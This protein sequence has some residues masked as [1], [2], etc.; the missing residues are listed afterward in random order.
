MTVSAFKDGERKEKIAEFYD[1]EYPT[2]FLRG[3]LETSREEETDIQI[4]FIARN[5]DSRE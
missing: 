2:L 4:M 3:L 5:N 1:T